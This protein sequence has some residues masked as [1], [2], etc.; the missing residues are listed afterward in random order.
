MIHLEPCEWT[1]SI[2]PRP[3]REGEVH[4][5]R[6]NLDVASHYLS[7]FL[8]LL[9]VDEIERAGRFRFP[10]HRDRFVARRGI[11][12]TL[13]GQ[14]LERP[15]QT[16]RFTCSAYG[17]PHLYQA[18][19]SRLQFNLSHSEGLALIALTLGRDVGIDVE[20]VTS[21]LRDD[22]V[23]EQFFHPREVALLRSLPQS[24]QAQAFLRCWVHKEAYIKA[25]GKG[26]SLPLHSFDTSQAWSTSAC[27]G[28]ALDDPETAKVWTLRGLTP[29]SGYT[30]ALVAE[31]N[32]WKPVFWNF[33]PPA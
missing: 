31:G 18:P 12:R 21:T 10:M 27:C 22:S 19:N 9:S 29:A 11:L 4:I 7:R 16:I 30:A 23:P 28:H 15:P 8:A 24:D 26:L 25:L 2:S 33:L 3:L 14:A 20:R 32:N 5:W 1:V 13:L 6:A 17:K